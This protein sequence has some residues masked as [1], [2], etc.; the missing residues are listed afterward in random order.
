[1]NTDSRSRK[2]PR[3]IRRS[4]HDRGGNERGTD[5]HPKRSYSEKWRSQD[6]QGERDNGDPEINIQGNRVKSLTDYHGYEKRSHYQTNLYGPRS[7]EV[8]WDRRGRAEGLKVLSQRKCEHPGRTGRSRSPNS[9]WSQRDEG[10]NGDYRRLDRREESTDSDSDT[11]YLGHQ[12]DFI[13]RDYPQNGRPSRYRRPG[14]Q[15]LR[16]KARE[17]DGT[18]SWREYISHFERVCRINGWEGKRLDYLWVNLSSTALA[19]A[20]NL[21][22][23]RTSTYRALVKSLEERF[24]DS[25]LADIYKAELRTRRRKEEESLQELGQEIR[26]LVQY[27]YP[28]V[29]INGVEELAIERFRE[30]L[31]NAD[32]RM[33]VHQAH[34]RNLEEA[35]QV[36]MDL[37]AWQLAEQ[38]R[39]SQDRGARFRAVKEEE[40]EENIN[41]DNRTQKMDTI[42]D[43][44]T[45]KMIQEQRRREIKCFSCGKLGHIAKNCFLKD[46]RQRGE[47]SDQ[48]N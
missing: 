36:A 16:A 3:E 30:A 42:I 1:V 20:E 43:W 38:R 45:K 27:A 46:Q 40:G 33:S 21:P 10:F 39:G 24:G 2:Y 4:H 19:Y 9:D 41:Q 8:T 15:Q 18:S 17:F 34:P 37:E 23:R 13:P 26:R 47:A 32:Q 28:G 48:E 14:E 11:A 6:D 44:V 7:T 29:G 25:K 35:I 5:N 22:R 12:R 31:S